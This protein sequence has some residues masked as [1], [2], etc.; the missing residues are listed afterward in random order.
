MTDTRDQPATKGD[1]A[2]LKV[3]MAEREVGA[4]KWFVGTFLAVQIAYFFGTLAAVWFSLS[5]LLRR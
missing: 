5:T 2:D 3:Y 4:L 1:I